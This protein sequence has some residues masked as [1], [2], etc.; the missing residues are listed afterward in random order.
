MTLF[1]ELFRNNLI[2]VFVGIFIT[3]IALIF[4]LVGFHLAK[5]LDVGI[6]SAYIAAVNN[7]VA[8][9]ASLIALSIPFV[10]K[11]VERKKE[12]ESEERSLKMIIK[13]LEDYL[14]LPVRPEDETRRP[15]K[16]MPYFLSLS[17]NNPNLLLQ[18]GI[19]VEPISDRS[20]GTYTRLHIID[21]YRLSIEIEGLRL[22]KKEGYGQFTDISAEQGISQ[23]IIK[24]IKENRKKI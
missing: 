6:F 17:N 15:S 9:I 2:K 4:V 11:G 7:F 3:L 8:I 13:R 24:E 14:N 19:E 23:K 18:L 16:N 22:E 10:M 12:A 21:K 20:F 1:K 5:R